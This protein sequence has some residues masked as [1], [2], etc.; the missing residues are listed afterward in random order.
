[1]AAAMMGAGCE[2]ICEVGQCEA[3]DRVCEHR[4]DFAAWF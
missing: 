4:V 3:V 1:M 2:P